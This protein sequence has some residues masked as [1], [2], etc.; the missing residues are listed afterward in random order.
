MDMIPTTDL[1]SNHSESEDRH[2]SIE[3]NNNPQNNENGTK[4]SKTENIITEKKT[5]IH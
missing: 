2:F 4:L 1:N 3:L 5:Q